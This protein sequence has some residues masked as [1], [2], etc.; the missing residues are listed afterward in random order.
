MLLDLTAQSI[1]CGQNI[2]DQQHARGIRRVELSADPTDALDTRGVID[3]FSFKL[4]DDT[5]LRNIASFSDFKHQYRWD[6]DGSRAAFVDYINPDD[7]FNADLPTVTEELQAQG[8]TLASGLK[9]VNGGYSA[10]P[11]A[12]AISPEEGS[13]A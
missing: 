9:S 11:K 7:Q 6:L 3:N 8:T 1:N 13:G 4:G 2:L 5:T 10:Y 12:P